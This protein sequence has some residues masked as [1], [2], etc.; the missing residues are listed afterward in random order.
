MFPLKYLQS[1]FRRLSWL[2]LRTMGVFFQATVYP[3]YSSRNCF[4]SLLFILDIHQGIALEIALEIFVQKF[5]QKNSGICS[6][7]PFISKKFIHWF[8]TEL[9]D[10]FCVISGITCEKSLEEY[11]SKFC[12]DFQRHLMRYFWRCTS[13]F[14]K[15]SS[16]NLCRHHWRNFSK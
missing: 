2:F 14:L 5:F 4:F 3:R 10:I 11:L 12:R 1:Y 15:K 8:F 7:G 13:K 6:R 9:L 16:K